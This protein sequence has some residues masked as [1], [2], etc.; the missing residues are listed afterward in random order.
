MLHLDA[1]S[2]RLTTVLKGCQHSVANGLDYPPVVPVDNGAKDVVALVHH[3]QAGGI[4]MLLEVCGRTLDVGEHHDDI[5]AQ[6]VQR[7]KIFAVAPRQVK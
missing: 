4:P 5:A 1:R 2:H 3:E 6:L 7:G